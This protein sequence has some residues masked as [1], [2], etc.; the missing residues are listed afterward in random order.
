MVL[1]LY[2]LNVS[3]TATRVNQFSN[4]Y[5][6]ENMNHFISR[7]SLTFIMVQLR[8]ISREFVRQEI[9]YRIVRKKIKK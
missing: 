4:F 9:S 2:H 8:A 6:V 3:S 5:H 1:T 7:D